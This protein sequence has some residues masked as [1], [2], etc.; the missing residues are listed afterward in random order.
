M[1]SVAE[2]NSK[3]K[4]KDVKLSVVLILGPLAV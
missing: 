4:E 2:K 1:E 3:L